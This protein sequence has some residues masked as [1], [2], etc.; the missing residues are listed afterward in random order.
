M[1]ETTSR[2]SG[3][4]VTREIITKAVCGVGEKSFH[5]PKVL[6]LPDDE[7]LSKI[8]GI[9]ITRVALPEPR[10]LSLPVTDGIF[11]PVGGSFDIN[12]WYSYNERLDTAVLRERTVVSELL[13]VAMT[14]AL[15]GAEV[16]A[17]LGLSRAPECVSAEAQ[18]EGAIRV[19]VVFEVQAEV[20]AETR[21][22]VQ[23][24]PD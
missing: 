12:V 5:Y 17:R 24:V 1:A 20:I 2:R 16:K 23:V 14:S 18:G 7:S 3:P 9:T 19:T 22:A 15:A 13:P 6:R 10:E 11:V 21:V 4:Y 8:L